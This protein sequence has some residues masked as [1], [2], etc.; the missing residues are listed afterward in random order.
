M[1]ELPAP[2]QGNIIKWELS[3]PQREL[4]AELKTL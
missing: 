3:Q 2:P 1:Q 4:G